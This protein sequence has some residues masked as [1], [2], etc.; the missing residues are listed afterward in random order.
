MIEKTLALVAQHRPGTFVADA[1]ASYDADELRELASKLNPLLYSPSRLRGKLQEYGVTVSPANFYA[2]IPSVAEIEEA[3]AYEGEPFAEG[4]DAAAQA[5]FIDE[6]V[7]IAAEFDPPK[8]PREGSYAWENGQFSYSDAM[9]YYCLIRKHRP[10]RIV[11]IGCGWS[12]LV[13]LAAL[14]ANGSGALTCVEPYPSEMLQR[15]SG[16]DLLRR[17]AQDLTPGELNGLLEDGDMVFI[18]ST[19]TVKHDSDCVHIYLRLL[20]ALTS[21]LLVHVHDIRLPKTLSKEMMRDSQIYWTEQYLLYAY[22]LDN[23]R[24]RILYGSY[25][26]SLNLGGKLD[27]LMH[28]RWPAGGGSLWFTQ[29]KRVSD[30]GP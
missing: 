30:P 23:P 16:F 25:F 24:C 17:R 14:K 26:A 2:E 19:H 8:E 10:K 29:R 3:S 27:E 5:R 9:V 28:G 15:A 4:F 12:S 6:L 7:G 18:D 11:E 21:D 22:L 1:A 20:P 13:A